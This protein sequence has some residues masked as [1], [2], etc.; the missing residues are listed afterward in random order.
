MRMITVREANQR[1][2]R[3]LSEVEK[4][5]TI[6]ITKNGQIVAE[7]RPRPHDPRQDSEWRRAHQRLV[8]CLRSWPDRGYIVGTISEA[9]KYEDAPL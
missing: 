9:D 8:G 7:L 6:L 1:F 4:G 3:V 5:E 2:S